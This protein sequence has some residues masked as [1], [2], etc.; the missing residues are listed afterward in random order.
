MKRK[1]VLCTFCLSA[2]C[3]FAAEAAL[4]VIPL[5]GDQLE[6]ALSAIGKV[7]YLNDTLCVRDKT[8]NLLYGEALRN[9]GR[10]VYGETA[11]TPTGTDNPQEQADVQVYPNPTQGQLTVRNA[12]G[13]AARIYE[14]QGKAVLAAPIYEGTATVDVSP[15]PVGT[16][17]LLVQNGVFQ[18]IKQ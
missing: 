5:H 18:F 10:I 2:V 3:L 14:M 11:E 12:Q 15:L 9:V 13:T 16:Y 6:M 17:L 7:V 8:G 1:I 4:Q